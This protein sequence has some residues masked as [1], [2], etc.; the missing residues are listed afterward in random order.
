MLDC[1]FCGIRNYILFIMSSPEFCSVS[2]HDTIWKSMGSTL[3]PSSGIVS[4]ILKI[5]GKKEKSTRK[6]DFGFEVG[7]KRCPGLGHTRID[8]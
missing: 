5:K 8:P 7:Q 6:P 2:A 3:K 4:T 1:E